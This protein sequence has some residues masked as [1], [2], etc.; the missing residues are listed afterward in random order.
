MF[1]MSR[2][3]ALAC[4]LGGCVESTRQPA[5]E[6]YYARLTCGQLM[7]ESRRL[8]MQRTRRDEY[9]L[10]DA[11]ANRKTAALQLKGVRAAITEK[12]C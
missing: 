7:A 6:P 9:L 11:A 8:A 2:I 12:N 1:A 5:A 10:V 3:V 4:V